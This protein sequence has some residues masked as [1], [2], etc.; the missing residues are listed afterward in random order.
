MKKILSQIIAILMV[1]LIVFS[2]ASPTISYAVNELLTEHQLENQ[3]VETDNKSVEFDVCAIDDKHT[4]TS[5][6]VD[7]EGKIKITVNVKDAGYLDDATVDFSDA[8][9]IITA[10]DKPELVGE[11]TGKQLKLNKINGGDKVVIEATIKADIK[12]EVEADF[13]NKD[14]K[15]IFTAK[16]YN[17]K[18]KEKSVKKE[19]IIHVSWNVS[20]AN[21][22][23]AQGIKKYILVTEGETK[24]VLIQENISA[25]IKDNVL[26]IKNS[27]IEIDVP[28]IED[29]LPTK[30]SVISTNLNGTNGKTESFN[31][32]NW[33]YEE[34]G[35]LTIDVSNEI[36]ENK[37]SWVKNAQDDFAVIYMYSEEVLNKIIEKGTKLVSSIKIEDTLYNSTDLSVSTE[38]NAETELKEQI[39]SIVDFSSEIIQD[40]INKGFLYNNLKAADED[41]KE[42]EY[43]E[44]YLLVIS[45]AELSGKITIK[46]KN[47]YLL[48]NENA[49]AEANAVNKTL[50][51]NAEEIKKVLGENGEIILTSNG[52]NVA[53][54]N[55]D[56][57]VDNNGEYVVTFSNIGNIEIITSKPE[58][59]GSIEFILEKAIDSNFTT[60]EEIIKSVDR[61]KTNTEISIES[62]LPV[63]K[64]EG[65]AKLVEPTSK[66]SIELNKDSFSTIS[67][68]NKI[69]IKAILESDSIDDKL[70]N[71]TIL[72]ISLPSYIKQVNITNCN[73]L[74]S[75]EIIKTSEQVL[76]TA[77]GKVIQ[78]LLSGNQ[79]K[80]N[81]SVEK[82]I[83]VVINADIEID[84]LTPSK[85]EQINLSYKEGNDETIYKVSKDI[86]FV[87]P[88]GLVTVSELENYEEDCEKISLINNE[89]EN[90]AYID[91]HS[92]S[93]LATYKGQI[94]NNYKNDISEAKILGSIPNT[95]KE[96]N[97]FNIVLKDEIKVSEENIE[98]YYSA[99]A[100]ADNDLENS[101]NGWSKEVSDFSKVKSYLIIKTEK[102]E[103]GSSINF[104]IPVEIPEN[105][106]FKNTDEI[107]YTVSYKNNTNVGTISENVE[108]SK[109]IITTGNG[110]VFE[111]EILIDENSKNVLKQSQHVNFTVK[112]KNTGSDATD[113]NLVVD[114]TNG[115][116][117]RADYTEFEY[118]HTDNEFFIGNINAGETKEIQ[119]IYTIKSNAEIG[120]KEFKVSLNSKEIT[121]SVEFKKN[122]KIEKGYVDIINLSEQ[123]YIEKLKSGQ[124]TSFMTILT[125]TSEENIGNFTI[126]YKVSEGSTIK[127]AG[128]KSS[129]FDTEL[130]DENVTIK[131]GI[132]TYTVSSLAPDA[133]IIFSV[134]VA[135]GYDVEKVSAISYTEGKVIGNNYSNLEEKLVSKY[136]ISLITNTNNEKDEV[137]EGQEIEYN[138]IVENIGEI[139]STFNT[140]KASIPDGAK[141]KYAILEYSENG[142]N[143][144]RKVEAT[145]ENEISISCTQIKVGEKITIK[146]ILETEVF[147]D[148]EI[149]KGIEEKELKM[150]LTFSSEF[151]KNKTS[152]PISYYVIYNEKIHNKLVGKEEEPEEPEKPEDPENP[153]EEE[154]YKISGK[155]WL[156]YNKNDKQ[157]ESEKGISGISV[158]LIDLSTMD[159]I[160]NSNDKEIEIKTSDD[161]TYVFTDLKKGKYIV[162]FDYENTEYNISQYKKEGVSTTVNSDVIEK[163]ISI[164]GKEK[165]VGLSD[166]LEINDSNIRNIDL[167]LSK[168]SKF[169]I[170]LTKR[171]SK[172]TINNDSGITDYDYSKNP[173]SLG[174]IEIKD[175]YLNSS[176]VIVEYTITVKNTGDVSGYVTSIVDYIPEELKFSSELNKDWYLGTDGNA[177]NMTLAKDE[178]KPTE[179]REVT[180]ILSKKMT[181]ENTGLVNND[182][183]IFDAYNKEGITNIDAEPGN[184]NKS[185]NDMSSASLVVSVKTGETV[186]KYTMLIIAI[187]AILTFGI[188]MIKIKILDKKI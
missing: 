91:A 154:K 110:P 49:V 46:Q 19:M 27:H 5:N 56:T 153:K 148:D 187:I 20:E 100:N 81:L 128:I 48:S 168:A 40:E 159:F 179:S 180:I 181:E 51:V 120:D 52:E 175:K 42:T 160:K 39:G 151:V 4:L 118:V 32:E 15:A 50:R 96:G 108:A 60:T 74:Y 62:A 106:S 134:E 112:V 182:A 89:G 63:N 143:K 170:E 26:P 77:N 76:D 127:S 47:S 125:N 116:V 99:N 22:I 117:Q 98:V 17:E 102:I 75:E 8:N 185:E 33:E 150:S 176:N 161:G 144:T 29:E 70:H 34:N 173:K 163:V 132:A 78:V 30:V 139:D 101:A 109:I 24:G 114:E 54:I 38:L 43:S 121:N 131:D 66:A 65:M 85:T 137:Y 87:A 155:V 186:T 177:Y 158:K 21:I 167:G 18:N 88:T 97:T 45:D 31:E 12:E 11:N 2:I 28:K 178:I 86:N 188:Y 71:N 94:I 149:K 35:K 166:T 64:V 130:K 14:N 104:E 103:K 135:I 67:Q 83:N 113:V 90:T 172:I 119:F 164:D 53:V 140:M 157:D 9:F 122:I 7:D 145:K 165:T 133:R 59:N 1:N 41:K 129:Y 23:A 79:T 92:N 69:E 10:I 93:A 184:K 152:D 36:D 6:L 72:E 44:K 141:I 171:V 115:T 95:E 142:E 13:F 124:T 174:K 162:V 82:G 138:Y 55:K 57:K 169:S 73:V 61:I 123:S 58:K 147:S 146:I 16:Y 68:N 80:Y 105:I 126:N 37:V 25:A 183:E 156:D 136:D 111:T 107:T 3:G 84:R